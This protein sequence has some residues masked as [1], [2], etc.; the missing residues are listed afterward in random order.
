MGH[1]RGSG[2]SDGSG[3]AD[4]D[5]GSL[6]ANDSQR[7]SDEG[8]ASVSPRS[9]TAKASGD[10]SKDG[11]RGRSKKGTS[12]GSQNSSGVNGEFRDKARKGDQSKL[13]SAIPGNA[14][15]ACVTVGKGER[16]A[17]SGGIAVAGFEEARS[18]FRSA[19][20]D[21][22]SVVHLQ[23]I[24]SA[25]RDAKSVSVHLTAP[26]GPSKRE[27]SNDRGTANGWV[28]FSVPVR[29]EGP[30]MWVMEVS[31]GSQSGCFRIPFKR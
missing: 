31:Y 6:H 4:S 27:T 11:H 9:K 22:A 5:K 16:S 28:Y 12:S 15:D 25:V 20:G 1:P 19:K 7:G 10:S 29:I 8:S 30:G 21:K 14:S 18:G 17:R 13:V 24:P 26:N 23:V 3:S 2:K